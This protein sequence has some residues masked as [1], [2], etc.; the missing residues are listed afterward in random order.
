[1]QLVTQVQHVDT[2][3]QTWTDRHRYRAQTQNG[4][5]HT[6]V[7]GMLIATVSSFLFGMQRV[8]R[9]SAELNLL[10]SNVRSEQAQ[11]R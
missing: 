4:V 7:T 3:S 5:H 6:F 8:I 1:M 9:C 11:D 10:Q 2:L